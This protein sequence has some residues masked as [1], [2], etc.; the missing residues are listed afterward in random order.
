MRPLT[1]VVALSLA[2]F[3]TAPAVA[4]DVVGIAAC[5]D[6]L[7]KYETCARDKMPAAQRSAIVDSI[8][9]MRSGW[10]QILT[11]SPQSRGDL[12]ATCRQTMDSMK[13]SLSSTYGCSF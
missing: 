10:K 11:S 9:A 12:E 6:F 2:V 1:A 8:N 3:T 4:Q 5:D 13:A 7:A